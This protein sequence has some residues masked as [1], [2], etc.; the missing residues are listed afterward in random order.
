M[1][2][3]ELNPGIPEQLAAL[4]NEAALAFQELCVVAE[5]NPWGLDPA[6]ETNPRGALRSALFGDPPLGL[7]RFLILEDQ[8]RVAV[9]AV[10]WIG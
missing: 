3:V 6:H 2:E 10:I 5:V 1:Y 7:A 9:V 4:P 8:R